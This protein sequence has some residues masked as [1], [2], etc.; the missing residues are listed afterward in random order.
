[1]DRLSDIGTTALLLRIPLLAALD[2]EERS[3]FARLL[4]TRSYAAR[5]TVVWEG[6][7]SGTL[8]IVLSGYLKAT[9]AGADGSE[10]LLSIMGPGEVFGE[11]SLLDGLPRSA[12]VST[13]EAAELA[14]IER[15]PFMQMVE[16]SPK[17]A[18]RLLGVLTQRLRN[19]SKRCENVACKDVR[20]RLAQ[21]LVFLA[22]RHGRTLGRGVEIPVKLSQQ[23]LGSM[24]GATRESVNKLLR[25]WSRSGVLSHVSG[26][27]TI[28]N[29]EV[30]RSMFAD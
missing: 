29:V 14:F 26:R 12:S 16:G 30:L 3:L 18:I 8:Y 10:L 9:T 21:A 11:L 23:D 5:Q 19:L 24:V 22:E 2:P 4:Q 27:V 13:L 20:S 25:N 15:E 1:M 7:R 6:E 17:L 28:S